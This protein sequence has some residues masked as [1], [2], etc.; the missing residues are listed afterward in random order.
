MMAAMIAAILFALQNPVGI[1]NDDLLRHPNEVHLLNVRQLT[2]GGQNAEAYWNTDGTK[3]IYQS[4][5]PEWPDEQ[6]LVMNADGSGKRLVSPGTGRCTCGYFIP[7][8]DEVVFSW[9][10][11][12][13]PG[14]QPRV[15]RSQGYVWMVNPW[16]RIFRAKQ[17]GSNRRMLLERRGYAAETTIAPDGSFMVFT[18]TMD[19]DLEIYRMNLDGTGLMRLTNELGY[20]GGPFVSWDGKKI[21][22]RRAAIRSERG[23]QDYLSLLKQSLVRPSK[24]EIW[25]MDADGG[26]KRQV[27]NLDAASFAPFL[28][29]NGRDI[30]FSTNY[31]D[32]QGREFDLWMI[33]VDG[34]GLKRITFT[35]EFDGF[36]MFTRDGKRLVWASNRNGREPGETNVFV[37]DW[38]E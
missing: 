20:D 3:I 26:N 11:W 29:P 1:P 22:Y 24:L 28:H 21:V 4:T 10:G 30:I 23:R 12:W 33:R 27:T 15:D 36:P 19:G 34:T 32:P 2:F 17:D 38:K 5:Q 16:Y 6:I 25:I 31:G 18:S 14:P 7:G 8:T 9:S 13:D 35:P 37:A